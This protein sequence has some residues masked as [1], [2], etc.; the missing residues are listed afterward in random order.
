MACVVHEAS[1][2]FALH[3]PSIYIL[4]NDQCLQ[5]VEYGVPQLGRYGVH[6]HEV[7]ASHVLQ[8]VW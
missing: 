5:H 3:S 8:V 7:H 6:A 2:L 1:I 4:N